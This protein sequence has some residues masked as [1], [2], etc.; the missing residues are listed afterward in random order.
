M[1]WRKAA[2]TCCRRFGFYTTRIPLAALAD[3]GC[4]VSLEEAAAGNESD[5]Y[6]LATVR[7]ISVLV[8]DDDPDVREVTALTLLASGF[9][10][11]TA[12][13]GKIALSLLESIR[14][15]LILLDV[16]MP[17]MDGP[18]FRQCQRQNPSLLRIPTVVM[19]AAST[20]P[21]L[22]VAIAETLR[23]PVGRAALLQV[24][25]RYCC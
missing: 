6:W 18:E 11:E 3:S 22:D 5:Q 15:A 21:W 23:K 24:V 25:R 17:I 16:M 19:T 4:H 1:T 8:I 13:N 14:P 9:T 20:E 12:A 10:V 7:S 2:S